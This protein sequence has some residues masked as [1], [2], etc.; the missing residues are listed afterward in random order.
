ML[1]LYK[2]LLFIF[3]KYPSAFEADGEVEEVAAETEVAEGEVVEATVAAGLAGPVNFGELDEGGVM[4]LAR[5]VVVLEAVGAEVVDELLVIG[6]G[7]LVE[8]EV[9]EV[10]EHVVLWRVEVVGGAVGGGKVLKVVAEGDVEEGDLVV[11]GYT[12]PKVKILAKFE[13]GFEA[14][15]LVEDGPRNGNGAS[16][17]RHG[18]GFGVDL[19]VVDVT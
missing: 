17:E 3:Q 8:F 2:N 10:E 14:L 18:E 6:V 4:V 15:K 13:V 12:N 9:V 19:T 16:P 1:Y 7:L 5:E 11:E